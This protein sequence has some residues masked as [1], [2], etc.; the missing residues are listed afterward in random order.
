M[1]DLEK[2]KENIEKI[3][4]WGYDPS[5]YKGGRRSKKAEEMGEE[6][7]NLPS[8]DIAAQL[9]KAAQQVEQVATTSS[10]L[11]GGYVKILKEA[12]LKMTLGVDALVCRSLPKEN[13]NAR[14]MERLREEVRTLKEE[15]EKLRIRRDQDLMPPPPPQQIIER[16]PPPTDRMEVDEDEEKNIPRR[17]IHPPKEK[18]RQLSKG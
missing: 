14:E 5:E 18:W 7:Q 6:I 16:E 9:M 1:Q 8:R 13:E 2:E 3:L 17:R 15:M 10:N 11:K 4:K 12:V